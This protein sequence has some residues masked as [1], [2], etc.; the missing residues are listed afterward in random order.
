M[1]RGDKG[2]YRLND[3]TKSLSVQHSTVGNTGRTAKSEDRDK[4]G[5][6]EIVQLRKLGKSDAVFP[7]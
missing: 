3:V 6:R 5:F 1:R 4:S 2:G 7:L